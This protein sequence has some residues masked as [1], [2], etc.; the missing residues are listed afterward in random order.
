MNAPIYT[1]DEMVRLE[2]LA[3]KNPDGLHPVEENWRNLARKLMSHTKW[4]QSKLE[5]KRGSFQYDTEMK[6]WQSFK[7]P[8]AFTSAQPQTSE[9]ED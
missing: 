2:L 4:I 9:G 5:S 7:F 1:P 8:E 3:Y 6:S